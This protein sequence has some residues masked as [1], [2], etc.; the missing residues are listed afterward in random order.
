LDRFVS[1]WGC[2]GQEYQQ[3][4]HDGGEPAGQ[5]RQTV[6]IGLTAV[7]DSAAQQD[8]Q[9]QKDENETQDTSDRMAWRADGA[10]HPEVCAATSMPTTS[11]RDGMNDRVFSG[12]SDGFIRAVCRDQKTVSRQP[13]PVPVD[14]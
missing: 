1:P 8:K 13:G 12:A 2:N 4:R 11:R 9:D 6:I 10:H 3:H 14:K 5:A 7:L